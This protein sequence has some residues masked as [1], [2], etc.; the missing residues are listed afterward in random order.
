MK[1]KNLFNV[2]ALIQAI[3][4]LAAVIAVL[5]IWLASLNGDGPVKA[6]AKRDHPITNAVYFMQNDPA[7]AN[8][9]LG[10]SP[11][12]M[13]RS[14]CLVCCIAASLKAQ[15]MD[16]DPGKLN[17]L[18][19]ENGVYTANGDI[20]WSRFSEVPGVT[21]QTPAITDPDAIESTLE[22]GA[23]PIVKVRYLGYGY[24]H[25]VLI[26]GSKDGE[27][28]CMDPLNPEKAPRPLSV[29]GDTIYGWRVVYIR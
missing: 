11:Y 20:I 16:T 14:G 28:L 9:R 5:C 2:A 27:Y 6:L 17:A 7:W 29:H 4:A 23:C 24:A 13:A 26:T 1:T 8:D 3:I 12:T 18:F 10:D 21:A 15:G 22:K 19:S 25:W